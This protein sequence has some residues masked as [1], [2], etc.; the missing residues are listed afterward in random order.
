MNTIINTVTYICS[1]KIVQ[2]LLHYLNDGFIGHLQFVT[3]VLAA[4]ASAL[5]G[6]QLSSLPKDKTSELTGL[7]TIPFYAERQAEKL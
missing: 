7:H 6:F 3:V 4:P 2:W 5:L 1:Y